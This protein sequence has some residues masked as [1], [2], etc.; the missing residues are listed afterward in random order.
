MFHI[1]FDS[2]GAKIAAWLLLLIGIILITGKALVPYLIENAP[3]LKK[4]F[5]T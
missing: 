4:K 1:L 5:S 2:T 3:K